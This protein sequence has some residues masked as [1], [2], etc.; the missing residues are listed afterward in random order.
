MGSGLTGGAEASID[1]GRRCRREGGGTGL[2]DDGGEGDGGAL[3]GETLGRL[4]ELGGGGG[5][6]REGGGR[7][8]AA[9]GQGRTDA[10]EGEDSLGR[11]RTAVEVEPTGPSVVVRNEDLDPVS[12]L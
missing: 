12:R 9:S 2:L 4:G 3:F 1:E 8:I 6:R 11:R 10:V 5:G 7:E